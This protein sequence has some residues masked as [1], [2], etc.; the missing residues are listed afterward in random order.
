[1]TTNSAVLPLKNAEKFILGGIA[2]LTIESRGTGERFTYR[3]NALD[4]EDNKPPL[5]WVFLLTG[6]NNLKDYE[7]I[8]A[9]RSDRKRDQCWFKHTKA[10]HVSEDAKSFRSFNWLWQKLHAK[11]FKHI[12]E[13]AV[14]YHMGRCA[15]CGRALTV[16]ASIACGFGPEC[17]KKLGVPYGKTEAEGDNT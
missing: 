3:V 6:P 8:G 1:M 2:Y 16:P 10:S 9:I 7:Y 11:E 14:V 5:W 15:R 12:A 4:R 13:R 17:A